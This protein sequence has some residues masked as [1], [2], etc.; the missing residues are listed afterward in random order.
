MSRAG[1]T[2]DRG[3]R[4]RPGPVGTSWRV[5]PQR[6]NWKVVS[7]AAKGVVRMSVRAE[8]G[9]GQS[10]LCSVTTL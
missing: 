2:S 4:T 7:H 6:V 10:S 3:A 5:T 9:D 1:C 8:A